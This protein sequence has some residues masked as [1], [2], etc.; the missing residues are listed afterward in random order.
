MTLRGSTLSADDKKK[1][2]VDSDAAG[3]GDLSITKVSSA[4]RLLVSDFLE[5]VS[6][7]TSQ[8]S[9]EPNRKRTIKP[10]WLWKRL[11][12]MSMEP[13]QPKLKIQLRILFGF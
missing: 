10:H 11:M 12:K 5:L 7:K 1:V 13:L 3:K 4:I 2:L 6:S 8:V 9:N